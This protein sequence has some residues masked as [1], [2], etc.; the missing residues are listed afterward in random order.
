M[1]EGVQMTQELKFEDRVH[2]NFTLQSASELFCSRIEIQAKIH[3]V[4]NRKSRSNNIEII[5]SLKRFADGSL[6]ND[7]RWNCADKKPKF[8]FG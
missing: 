3:E 8:R 6:P 5:L 4:E 7:M 2:G 1:K